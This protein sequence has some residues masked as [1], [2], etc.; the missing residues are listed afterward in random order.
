[1]ALNIKQAFLLS[2]LFSSLDLLVEFPDHLQVAFI[3]GVLDREELIVLGV[4]EENAE[5]LEAEE[6]WQHF[7]HLVNQVRVGSLS[8]NDCCCPQSVHDVLLTLALLSLSQDEVVPR[9]DE[10]RSHL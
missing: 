8:G 6:L 2:E 9:L 3:E 5:S 10:L 1:L 7:L 4:A